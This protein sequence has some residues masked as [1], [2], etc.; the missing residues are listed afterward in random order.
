MTR[1]AVPSFNINIIVCDPSDPFLCH[2]IY[3]TILRNNCVLWNG[4]L[5]SMSVCVFP[6]SPIYALK[7]F[8]LDNNE[9]ICTKRNLFILFLCLSPRLAYCDEKSQTF[10]KIWPHLHMV[11]LDTRHGQ[12]FQH[13]NFLSVLGAT[14]PLQAALSF[15]PYGILTVFSSLISL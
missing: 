3:I 7:R 2:F 1:L 10:A 5:M 8:T 6:L 14:R 13:L 4:R 11:Y 15:P 12:S 9:D